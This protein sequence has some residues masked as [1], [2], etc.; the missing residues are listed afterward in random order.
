MRSEHDSEIPTIGVPCLA[1]KIFNTAFLDPQST[2]A[3]QHPIPICEPKRLRK[4]YFRT[5]N[6]SLKAR[7][8]KTAPGG[9]P[10]VM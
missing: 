10:A 9:H 6:L 3:N 1:D 4:M 2:K 5:A 7:R 8:F